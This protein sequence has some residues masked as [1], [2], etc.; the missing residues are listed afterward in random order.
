MSTLVKTRTCIQCMLICLMFTLGCTNSE[1]KHAGTF[2]ARLVQSEDVEVDVRE[3][4]AGRIYSLYVK[5][6]RRATAFTNE[7]ILST[8]ALAFFN[9]LPEPDKAAFVQVAIEVDSGVV[10]N[11]FT[12]A[13]LRLADR[14][15]DRVTDF[16]KWHPRMGIDSLRPIVDSQFFPD[17]LIEKM[18]ASILLQDSLDNAFVRSEFFGFEADTVANVA[19]LTLKVA[20]TRKKTS[21]RYD[22]FVGM[23]SERLLLVVPSREN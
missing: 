9:Q 23:K 11:T 10:R 15:I 3:E 5:N 4:S 12:S 13:E 2:A 16:F 22:A 17:S 21:Q 6:A 14:C 1:L 19:V 20:A 7:D 18:G 8:C